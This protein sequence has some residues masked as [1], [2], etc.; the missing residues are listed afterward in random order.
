MCITEYNEETFVNGIRAEGI[1]E[2]IEEGLRRS[3]LSMLKRGH[4]IDE[5]V[6]FGGFD[7]DVVAGVA[8]EFLAVIDE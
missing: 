4:T 3:I 5:I 7:K 8:K 6:E 2:G 1:E